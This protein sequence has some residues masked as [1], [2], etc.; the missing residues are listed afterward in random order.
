[1]VTKECAISE[2]GKYDAEAM[3]TGEATENLHIMICMVFPHLF[4][5]GAR[6][7]FPGRPLAGEVN[8]G[9]QG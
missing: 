5:Y 4:T 3:L 6:S 7:G 9:R 1:M 8:D 2:F